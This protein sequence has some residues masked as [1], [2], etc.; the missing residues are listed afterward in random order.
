MKW[1]RENSLAV[2]N[3]LHYCL[4]HLLYFNLMSNT[5][6]QDRQKNSRSEE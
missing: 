6:F 1:Q 2:S 4:M 5:Q 3:V